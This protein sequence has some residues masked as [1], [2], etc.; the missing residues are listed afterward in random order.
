MSKNIVI[1]QNGNTQNMSVD[2]L[3]TS[4]ERGGTV[5]WIPEGSIDVA[6]LRVWRNGTYT[7][8]NMNVFGFD[9]VK[10]AIKSRGG[11]GAELEGDIKTGNTGTNTPNVKEGGKSRTMGGTDHLKVNLQSGGTVRF[12]SEEGIETDTLSVT[13]EGTYHASS[14]DKYAYKSVTVNV[15]DGGGGGGGGGGGDDLPTAISASMFVIDYVDGERI[16]YSGLVV[17]ALK[18]NQYGGYETWTSP[19]Y[20]N[21]VIP[22]NELN[23]PVS[24]AQYDEEAGAIWESEFGIQAIRVEC[25]QTEHMY[26]STTSSPW[27]TENIYV[28]TGGLG[29]HDGKPRT[30]SKKA[31][32]ATFLTRYDGGL[33]AANESGNRNNNMAAYEN[34]DLSIGWALKGSSTQVLPDKVF[35]S[36]I[37][38]EYFTDVPESSVNPTGHNISE[39]SNPHYIQWL[40]ISWQRPVDGQTLS[41]ET[42]VYV[43]PSHN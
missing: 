34:T 19:E 6:S 15:P 1:N 14:N 10:V 35:G 9:S 32:G 3:R 31:E 41:T 26:R 18:D 38:G 27:R 20:P 25:V 17:T 21:G 33:Y 40:P 29:V 42:P 12:I 43:H 30:I 28:Y 23:L 36:A 8:E 13:Q 24:T 4:D 16:D 22:L 37:W 11:A 2:K 7:A 5:D 39:L